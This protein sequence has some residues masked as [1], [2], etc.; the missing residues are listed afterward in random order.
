MFCILTHLKR[1][2][3]CSVEVNRETVKESNVHDNGVDNE[4]MLVFY[5]PL[6]STRQPFYIPGLLD[7][8][9]IGKLIRFNIIIIRGHKIRGRIVE[10]LMLVILGSWLCQGIRTICRTVY[11]TATVR[12]GYCSSWSE[13]IYDWNTIFLADL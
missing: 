10:S 5:L 2:R 1:R 11:W 3:V 4:Q 13:I 12:T 9:V 6:E 8:F 7:V